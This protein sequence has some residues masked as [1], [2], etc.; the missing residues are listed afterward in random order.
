MSR[1]IRPSVEPLEPLALLSGVIY[2]PGGPVVIGLFTTRDNYLP[3][4]P[5]GMAL[6]ETNISNHD[7]TIGVGPSLDGFTVAHDGVE[8]WRSNPGA[9]PN[10]LLPLVLHPHRSFVIRAVWNGKANVG[11]PAPTTGEFRVRTELNSAI[12]AVTIRVEPPANPLAV[13]VTTDHA[14]YAPGQVVQV[15]IAETNTGSRDAMIAQGCKILG[16]SIVRGD[17][18]IWTFED[19]RECATE[20]VPLHPGQTRR[21]AFA[22]DSRPP[23]PVFNPPPVLAPGDYTIRVT[24]DGVTATAPLRVRS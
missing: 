22:Y 21:L 23:G 16:L 4:Q 1:R 19:M 14:V 24:L 7:V 17:K 11:P 2:N 5:V 13:T 12:P 18:A 3:G 15:A 20:L 10:V 8:I 6:I 9:Q